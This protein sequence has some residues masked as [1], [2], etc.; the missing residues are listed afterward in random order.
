MY[1]KSFTR[2]IQSKYPEFVRLSVHPSGG[3]TKLSVP[4]IAQADGAFPRTPWHS[5]IAVGTNGSLRTCHSQEVSSTHRLVYRQGRP[6]YYR[7][8]SELWDWDE[9]LVHVEPLYPRGLLV[10]PLKNSAEGRVMLNERYVERLQELERS[11]GGPMRAIGFLNHGKPF[12]RAS[13]R[14]Y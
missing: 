8:K 12:I 3:T 9:E 13:S 11:F 1:L 7:E 6:Y 5:C 14:A 4:L 2:F 10:T